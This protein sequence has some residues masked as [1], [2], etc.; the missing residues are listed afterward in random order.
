MFAVEQISTRAITEG[1]DRIARE[2]ERINALHDAIAI[3]AA[4]LCRND[5]A[6]HNAMIDRLHHETN[7]AKIAYPP[8]DRGVQHPWP[9]ELATLCETIERFAR[10]PPL[11]R[12]PCDIAA[13]A[14]G[15][16]SPV[17]TP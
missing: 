12:Q 8:D 1:P 4:E 16:V 15:L 10:K 2:R 7:K 3:L 17:G 9:V 13:S 5:E 11:P 6:L 14:P